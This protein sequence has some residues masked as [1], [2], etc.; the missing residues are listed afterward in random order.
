MMKMDVEFFG[1][2]RV[3]LIMI[4]IKFIHCSYLVIV[5]HVIY[6]NLVY[7]F[8]LTTLRRNVWQVKEPES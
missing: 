4:S 3:I 1:A 8:V 2:F 6:T 7:L 5:L